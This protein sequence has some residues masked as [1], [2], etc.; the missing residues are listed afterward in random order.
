MFAEFEDSHD[1]QYTQDRQA[2]SF[3]TRTARTRRQGDSEENEKRNNGYYI[4][5]VDDVLQEGFFGWTDGEPEGHFNDEPDYT[6]GLCDEQRLHIIGD[7]DHCFSPI[8][9]D[10]L[11]LAVLLSEVGKSL[12]AECRY[13]DEDEYDG[14]NGDDLGKN[15][16]LWVFHH[17]KQLQLDLVLGLQ[18]HFMVHNASFCAPEFVDGIVAYLIEVKLVNEDVQRHL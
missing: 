8:N 14:E 13:G 3:I 11:V 6:T 1:S 12:H 10:C 15:R 16:A 17:F 18:N 7:F 2:A 5:P 4:N 9:D